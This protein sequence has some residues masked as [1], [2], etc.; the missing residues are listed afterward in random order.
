[1]KQLTKQDI[2]DI[3]KNYDLGKL[4]SHK[5]IFTAANLI[6]KIKTTKRRFILKLYLSSSKESII[7]QI[8]LMNFLNGQ[9]IVVPKTL[10]TI[11]KESLLIWKRK[12]I[13][14]QEFN[15]GRKKQYVN[16]ILAK[17]MGIKYGALDKA[18]NKY[19]T[20]SKNVE[21]KDIKQFTPLNWKTKS[22]SDI[23]IKKESKEVVKEIKK[24]K[25]KKLS[26]R[27]IHGDLGEGNFLVKNDK[28][29]TILDLDDIQINYLV[30][31][32][33]VPISQNFI[34]LTN[35]KKKLIKIFLKEYQKYIK[36]NDEEKKA[37]Y[38]FIKYQELF[39]VFWCYGQIEKFPKEKDELMRWAKT[40]LR[41][42]GLFDKIT[43][44]EWMKI[45]K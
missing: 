29:T 36:L 17:D 38:F 21:N 35:V 11:Q 12:K 23:D 7:N 26:R 30:C 1:M 33:A 18:L 2:D 41:Q 40:A 9:G 22:L 32:L 42:Y 5:R 8:N 14:I 6:Y 20:K 27:L 34:T 39:D 19:K 37:L 15:E 25:E 44:E 4:I 28:I 13:T 43:L 16:R 31:E 3:L 45:V 24:L 10:N